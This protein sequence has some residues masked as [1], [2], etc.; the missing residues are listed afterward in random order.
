MKQNKRTFLLS[1]LVFISAIILFI[2]IFS[3]L[4]SVERVG[5]LSNFNHILKNKYYFTLKF[6]SS[7]FKNNKIYR[8]YPNT[9]EMPDN[10]T[11]IRWSGSYYGNLVLGDSSIQLKENDK[12]ENIKYTVKIQKNVFLFLLFIIIVFPAIYFY[13]IPNIYYHHKSYIFF[14]VLNSLLYLMTSNLIMPLFSMMKL[15]FNIYDFLYTYL[16]VMIAYNL[17]V[18]YPFNLGNIKNIRIILTALFCVVSIFSFFAIES[19]SLTVLSMV[20]LFS[21]MPNLYSSLITVLPIHLKIITVTV[22]II[23]FSSLLAFVILFI[24]N[25]YKIFVERS[26]IASLVMIAFII[27]TVFYLFLKPKNIDIWSIDFVRNAK[28]NGIINTLNYRINY[29]R[30]NNIKPSKELVSDSIKLLKEY[31]SKRDVSKLYLKSTKNIFDNI[32]KIEDDM[33]SI[34]IEASSKNSNFIYNN[35]NIDYEYIEQLKNNYYDVYTNFEISITNDLS[36]IEELKKGLKRDVYLI[37][38]ESFYDY[39]HFRKLFNKDPFPKE[40]RKWADSSRKIAPNVNNGSFYARLSGLTGSSPLYPKTQSEKIENTLPD[41]L[42]KNGYNTITLEE[43]LNTYNLK[44]FYP[45][46]GFK[47]QLFGLGTTNINTYLGTNIDNLGSPVFA[48]GFTILGHT[49]SH[50]SNDLNFA[51][52]NKKFLDNFEG[53]DKLHIIE[54]IDNSAMTAINI[55]EIRDT[56]LKHS[57]NAIIIFKHDH[58]YPYLKAIIERSSIDE[59]IKTNFLNDYKPSPILIWDGTNGAYK[60]NENFTPENI[61][62]FIAANLN[63]DY[64]NS[65]I[66]LL[67]KEEIDDTISTYNKFYHT[68]ND[69]IIDNSEVSN[70]MI[71]KYENAQRTLSQDIFQGKKHYYNLIK[72]LTNN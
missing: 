42:S 58:L 69:S 57:P 62:L 18:Y 48:A 51:E 28:R 36:K 14:F 15:D 20:I 37:F 6:E 30:L 9:N 71:F 19:I 32:K 67:Y 66:S 27:F 2:V 12:I 34:L 68:T 7:I 25:I 59:K 55:I 61:P 45:S 35:E 31:E 50:L 60:A 40:Y 72:E 23:Y 44:T 47:S 8:V 64:T 17:L 65:V 46:I 24:F 33:H 56:I 11:N 4:G 38:L 43:A 1:Y 10:V 54:T 49:D 3:I 53:N 16:F 39:S 70:M 63:V 5:Y 22:S 13:V 21:D 26:K 41:I 29:D 52:N